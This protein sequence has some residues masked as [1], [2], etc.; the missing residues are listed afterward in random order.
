MGPFSLVTKL[1]SG[2]QPADTRH[3]LHAHGNL[4]RRVGH[5]LLCLCRAYRAV[6]GDR[7][8]KRLIVYTECLLLGFHG[9]QEFIGKLHEL[10]MLKT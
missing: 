8:A 2:N 4:R 1:L 5:D 9:L 10:L 3:T 7:A 6:T